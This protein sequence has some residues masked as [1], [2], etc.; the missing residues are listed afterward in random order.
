MK[1]EGEGRRVNENGKRKGKKVKAE[2][3]GRER[4][5]VKGKCEWHP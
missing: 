4:L 1:V 3:G 5:K 2:G